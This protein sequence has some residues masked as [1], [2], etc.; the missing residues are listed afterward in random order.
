MIVLRVTVPASEAIARLV[1]AAEA[2]AG[3][4]A[5]AQAAGEGETMSALD[6][7]VEWKN[8]RR[9]RSVE[10]SHDNGYGAACWEVHLRGGAG[11]F[12]EVHAAE[13]SFYAITKEDCPEG[14]VFAR[15]PWE[16]GS[17]D[18]RPGLEATILVA[19]ERAERLGL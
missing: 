16:H 12:K 18:E 19:L 17:G 13:V 4:R 14:L 7:L 2:R 15:P 3:S 6:K 10:I 8:S 1:L 5:Q 9:S 11:T